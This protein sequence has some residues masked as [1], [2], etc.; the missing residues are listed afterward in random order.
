MLPSC[1]PDREWRGNLHAVLDYMIRAR[2]VVAPLRKAELQELDELLAVIR[3][4]PIVAHQDPDNQRDPAEASQSRG[5]GSDVVPNLDGVPLDPVLPP[6][7]D[8]DED[9]QLNWELL[10]GLGQ[11][12]SN[13]DLML[14]L[15]EQLELGDC[16]NSF[17]L[18]Q[19]T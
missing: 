5:Q 4:H 9:L 3:Q 17:L 2:N 13:G 8:L 15:A 12:V 6:G 1:V 14:G 11:P 7:L 10:Y 16:E 18:S 19:L